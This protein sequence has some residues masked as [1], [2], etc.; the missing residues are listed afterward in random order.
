[1]TNASPII[2]ILGYG[3]NVGRHVAQAFTAKGYRVAVT[4]RNAKE[5]DNTSNQIHIPSN[6]SNPESIANIFS[7]VEAAFGLPSVVVYNGT[8]PFLSLID[9]SLSGR[10][11]MLWSEASAGK[12]NPAEDPLSV[13]LND[14]I[15]DLNV[16]TISA[17]VAAQQ[18]A[19]SFGKLPPSASKTFIYTGNITNT[20]PIASL[21]GAGVGKSATAHVVQVASQAYK[22]KGFKYVLPITIILILLE[23]ADRSWQVLLCWWA[24][25]WWDAR[26]WKDQ[27]GS[28]WEDVHS[29]CGGEWARAVAAYLCKGNRVSRFLDYWLK[30][31]S[32]K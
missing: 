11:L 6:F 31:G 28:A 15:Q 17:F 7:K 27:W 26:L 9:E 20:S 4:S 10:A 12:P 8:A 13:P 21:M 30:G 3:P 16:N 23:V 32:V 1:M 14:F 2:L 18:A 24:E 5:T 19:L 29:A 25:S 22:E